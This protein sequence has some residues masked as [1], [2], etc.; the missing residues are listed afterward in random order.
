[1][2]QRLFSII[3]ITFNQEMIIEE[4][5]DSILLQDHSPL[6]VIICDDASTDNTGVKCCKWIEKNRKK[7]YR[8]LYHRNEKNLGIMGNELTGIGLAQGVFLKVLAGDDLLAPGAIKKAAEYFEN[9]P[10]ALVV[11]GNIKSFYEKKDRISFIYTEPRTTAKCFFRLSAT[12]QFRILSNGNPVPAPGAFYRNSFFEKVSLDSLQLKHIE[13]WAVWLSATS[14][15]ISLNYFDFDAIY[16]RLCSPSK[17]KYDPDFHKE[18]LMDCLFLIENIIKPNKRLLGIIELLA[19]RT[20]EARLSLLLRDRKLSASIFKGLLSL[21]RPFIRYKLYFG[22]VAEM[23]NTQK[24][25]AKS[26]HHDSV[27]KGRLTNK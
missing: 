3:V 13:D 11:F 7:F 6:E 10:N 24:R 27:T 14:Q 1:M 22:V 15:H 23:P 26:L 18:C 4:T 21:F 19:V 5:L 8:V 12:E 2:A 20:N 17:E 25:I 9:N 16:Y